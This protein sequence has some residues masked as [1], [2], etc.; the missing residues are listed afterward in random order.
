MNDLNRLAMNVRGGNRSEED[1]LMKS[2]MAVARETARSRR[3]PDHDLDDLISEVSVYLLSRGLPETWDPAVGSIET[4]TR[5]VTKNKVRQF[6]ERQAA[7]REVGLG[8]GPDGDGEDGAWITWFLAD[9]PVAT[10]TPG[11][12]P[13]AESCVG[14]C[15]DRVT[16]IVVAKAKS[17]SKGIQ[18]H[19]AVDRVRKAVKALENRVQRVICLRMQGRSWRDIADALGELEPK[20]VWRLLEN[21]IRPIL[22]ETGGLS[23]NILP[24]LSS[25][26]PPWNPR[27]RGQ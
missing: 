19:E 1:T 15:F 13:C 7:S 26:K 18:Y 23:R 24:G 17:P 6:W 14:A 4:F 27:R 12:H 16:E 8:S 2:L 25:R 5:E 21:A 22:D 11:D 3:I 9:A 20:T 10:V